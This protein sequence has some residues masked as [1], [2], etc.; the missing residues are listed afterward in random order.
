MKPVPL[1]M[2]AIGSSAVV[3]WHAAC[4]ILVENQQDLEARLEAVKPVLRALAAK[5]KKDQLI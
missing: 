3:V 5:R 4:S 2:N 1:T